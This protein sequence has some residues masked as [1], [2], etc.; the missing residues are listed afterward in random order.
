MPSSMGLKNVEA[1]PLKSRV[2]EKRG[3]CGALPLL[4]AC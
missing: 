4:A 3:Y 2:A 1:I